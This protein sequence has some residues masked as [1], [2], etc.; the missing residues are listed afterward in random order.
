MKPPASP[1]PLPVL[2]ARKEKLE[3]ER[4]ALFPRWKAA[5]EAAGGTGS[6]PRGTQARRLG[7]T[8]AAS[9]AAS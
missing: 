8:H 1:P 5:L 9:A 2:G 4:R 7:G 3:A 6:E